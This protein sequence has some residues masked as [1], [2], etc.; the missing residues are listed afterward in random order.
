MRVEQTEVMGAILDGELLRAR[1]PETGWS[2]AAAELRAALL[3]LEKAVR[4]SGDPMR[5]LALAWMDFVEQCAVRRAVDDLRWSGATEDVED[6]EAIQAILQR[7]RDYFSALFL[8]RASDI[9]SRVIEQYADTCGLHGAM[10]DGWGFFSARVTESLIELNHK[11]IGLRESGQSDDSLLDDWRHQLDEA[12][13]IALAWPPAHAEFVRF[14]DPPLDAL[15]TLYACLTR[16]FEQAR[17]ELARE[18]ADSRAWRTLCVDI[19][20]IQSRGRIAD[21]FMFLIPVALFILALAAGNLY[22]LAVG[23][24]VLSGWRARVASSLSWVIFAIAAVAA[25]VVAERHSTASRQK[26]R[27]IG[28]A[29]QHVLLR[30]AALYDRLTST[31]YVRVT[32]WPDTKF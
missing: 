23:V 11:V 25:L 3:A 14:A 1:G 32:T 19:D 2:E 29:V 4:A 5:V 13:R 16:D 22:M 15:G 24:E 17:R 18:L 20:A 8:Y 12:R 7:H 21:G 30:D 28:V 27:E 6:A 9:G 10:R 26:T 31:G